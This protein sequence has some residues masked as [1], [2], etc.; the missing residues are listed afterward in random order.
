MAQLMQAVDSL[1]NVFDKYAGKD[2]DSKT[3]T[4]NELS[5]LLHKELDMKPSN[6]GAVEEFFKALDND[7]DGVVTFQEYVIF[8]V[9][10]CMM[11]KGQ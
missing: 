1:L 11:C 9:S 5:E 6:K 7:G 4:K 2:G 8:V 3:L 10:L